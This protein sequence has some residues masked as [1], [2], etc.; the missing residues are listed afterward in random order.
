MIVDHNKHSDVVPFLM[1][2]NEFADMTDEEI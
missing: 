1:E 2:V